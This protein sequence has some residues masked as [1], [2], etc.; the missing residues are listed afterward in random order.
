MQADLTVDVRRPQDWLAAQIAHLAEHD[1]RPAERSADHATF[2]TPYGSFR[3]SARGAA[4]RVRVEAD[5][6]DGLETLQ[7]AI[8]EYLI[9]QD[10]SLSERIEWQGHRAAGAAPMGF[11]VMEVVSR[12]LVSP[13][14]IRLTVK[15]EDVGHFG[16]RGLHV[17]LFLPPRVTD[18]PIVWPRRSASGAMVLPEGEDALTVRVYTVR[19]IRPEVGELDIDVVRHAGGAFSDWAEGAEPGALLGVMGPGG[20]F[21][22]KADWL[23]IGGDETALPAISRILEYLPDHVQGRA[24]IGLRH[25]D[26]RM[27]IDAPSGV[28][29]AWIVG[30]DTAL[31]AAM[32]A[33][34]LPRGDDA[35]VWFAGEAEAARRLRKTFK[36]RLGL[37]AERVSCAAYWRRD[38]P[39]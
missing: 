34:R 15:G 30:D 1:L 4:L 24:V 17:R 33:V 2:E 12:R 32:E 25:G 14:M 37:P 6:A 16:E 20:G 27:R 39:A 3:V 29:I 26:G 38:R 36:E 31:T 22:P 23:L 7:G 11:R 21:H 28:E 13:W 8:S 10:P 19:Q 9:A 35:A 18:R 5:D